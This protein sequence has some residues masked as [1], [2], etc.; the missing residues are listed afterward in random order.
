MTLHLG[1]GVSV[2]SAV[3]TICA[4]NLEPWSYLNFDVTMTI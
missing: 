2:S 3:A 1:V 4:Q